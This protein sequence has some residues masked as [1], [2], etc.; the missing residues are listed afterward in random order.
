MITSTLIKTK[1][2]NSLFRFFGLSTDTKPTGTWEGMPIPQGSSFTEMDTSK[3][4]FY[5]EDS[6]AWTIDETG[7]GG[8]VDP[9][10]IATDEEVEE[11]IDDIWP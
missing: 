6:S 7:G 2:Y 11:V 9:G 5:R 8:G 1:A 3:K 4:Y 10:D